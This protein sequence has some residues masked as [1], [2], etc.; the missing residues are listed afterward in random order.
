MMQCPKCRSTLEE[1]PVK[2]GDIR[3]DC[4][5][6]C[7][8]IW[9]DAGELEK[10]LKEAYR[11]LRVP[12]SAN[13]LSLSCPKCLQPLYGFHY[14]QTMVNVDVCK[15]CRGM[16]LDA[17]EYT[18]INRVREALAKHGK[19][20]DDAQPGPV[21]GTLLHWVDSAIEALKP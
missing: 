13:R 18:E 21:K 6:R 17:G 20:D 3:V 5:P 11:E 15:A 1:K 19:L 10:V 4:C 14:P 2:Q 7:R 8:G 16:W 12:A 9:F